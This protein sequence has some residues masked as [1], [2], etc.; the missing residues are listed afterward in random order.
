MANSRKQLICKIAE[1]H[2]KLQNQQNELMTHERYL[3]NIMYDQRLVI[4]AMLLPAFLWGWKHAK[5][6]S[7][8][9][10]LKKL[11]KIGLLAGL[12]HIRKKFMANR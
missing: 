3:T 12:S 1:T 8:P 9:N 5:N 7:I 2:L 11:T 6:P 10:T 4:V